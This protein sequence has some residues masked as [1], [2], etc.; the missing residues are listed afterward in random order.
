M[1]TTLAS[2]CV[3]GLVMGCERR[4]EQDTAADLGRPSSDTAVVS[5]AMADTS[6]DAK[7]QWGPAAAGTS[8][9]GE[10]CRRQR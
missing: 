9:W 2:L 7:L 8:R 5:G 4:A 1:R 3:L 10:G 6:A